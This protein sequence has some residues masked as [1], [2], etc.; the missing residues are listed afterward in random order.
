M[1]K[2]SRFILFFSVWLVV[3][4]VGFFVLSIYESS[5]GKRGET[6]NDWPSESQIIRVRYQPVVVMFA[7]PQ[8]PCTQAS[9]N[10]FSEMVQRMDGK[11]NAHIVFFKPDGFPDDWSKSALWE[12]ASQIP[13]VTVHLDAG[14]KEAR[15]FGVQTSG[16][17]LL[18]DDHGRLLFTGGITDGRGRSGESQSAQ[19]LI[20]VLNQASPLQASTAVY[21]CSLLNLEVVGTQTKNP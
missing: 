19:K 12:S 15:N 7:H 2:Q 1:V 21:G 6:P 13:G 14:N 18:Y 9:L 17:T 20:T 8:C 4:T 3:V 10:E 16:H 11:L 5:P